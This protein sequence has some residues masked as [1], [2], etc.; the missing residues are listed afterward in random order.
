MPREQTFSLGLTASYVDADGIAVDQHTTGAD[1]TITGALSTA[2][3]ATSD[4]M[5]LVSIFATSNESSITFSVWGTDLYGNTVTDTI[6]GPNNATVVSARYFY[7]VSRVA[8]SASVA[9]TG[10][11]EIDVGFIDRAAT[12]W[13][14][15]NS[16]GIPNNLTVQ[17]EAASGTIGATLQMTIQNIVPTPES[18]QSPGRKV[19]A[20]PLSFNHASIAAATQTM[21]GSVTGPVNAVRLI[22]T[23]HATL[24][25]ARLH[26]F[27]NGL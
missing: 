18:H 5:R 19:A 6:T 1:L 15:L 21:A 24:A 7:T 9:A 2:S 13:V 25:T 14:K 16:Y 17:F 20:Q 12:P 11:A 22:V 26:T 23:G 8:P 4:V 10:T 3:V 27:Q